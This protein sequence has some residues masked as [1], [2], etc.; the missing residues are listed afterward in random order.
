LTDVKALV[1][2]LTREEKAALTAGED[3]LST[4]AVERLG[5]PKV[6]V[7]DGPNGARGNSLPGMG[8]AASACIPCGSALG[9]TWNPGLVEALGALVGREARER[10][11]R[12]LLAPTVNLHR[13]PL[14]GRNFECYSED[15]LLSG[16]LAAGY[17]RGV[18]S[19]GVFATVKHFVGN[20]A[21]FERASISSVVDERSLRELYL[22]P[23][24]IAV[25]EGG[26]LAIMTAYNRLNGRW[27][28]QRAE[29]LLDILR[30]EWGFKG[31]VMTDWFAVTDTKV[32]LGAGL[33]LEM[34]GPARGLG[35]TVAAAIE[36]GDVDEADLDAAVS[37][38]LGAFDRIGALDG[39]APAIDPKPPTRG[40]VA[41]L[42]RAAAEATVLLS[43]DGVLPL[44]SAAGRVAL[45]GGP[46]LTPTIM[47]GGSA[48]VTPHRVENVVDALALALGPEC[49]VVYE[50]GC[51]PSLSPAVVGGAVL[52]APDGFRAETYDGL[53]LEGPVTE[54]QQLNELR[55]M[56]IG[57]SFE[58]SAGDWSMRVA[59]T[60]VPDETGIFELALA[61][62]GLARL[63][64]NDE[65]VLDGYTN[66]P[67]PGGN[68]FFGQAS[69]DLVADVHFEQGVPVDMVVEYAF[70]D[71]SLAGF[72][73][74]FRTPDG[75]ALLERAVAAAADADVAI[76]CV[77]TSAE[78]ETE[79]RDRTTLA[80]PGRQAE[81]V[82]RVA[83]VNN[84]TVVVVN[85]A[86]PVD[87]EWAEDVAAVLQC[88]F[89]GQE[90]AGG[91]VDVLVGS[92]EP[93]G[94]LPTTIPMRLEHAPS[95]AN[96]P[97]ENGE[98][99][100]GEGLFMG[101]RGYEHNAIAPRFAFGHGLSY[102]S[103]DLGEPTLSTTTH[104]SGGTVRVVVPV[105]NVG[106]RAGSEVVQCYVA[107]VSPR[108]ARPPKELKA[109]GKVALEP[110]ESGVVEF[111]LDD[112]AFA[113]WDPGQD[114]WN[115]VQAFV[116]EMFNFLSPPA[117]RRERGWQ[118][119]PGSYE[120]LI[121]R[122]SDD[123][124]HRCSLSVP[125]TTSRR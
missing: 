59:G 28:T 40:D 105:T 66:R 76:V 45:F 70:S 18:Q 85:A 80:L 111:V 123:L 15:P 117:P 39:P 75:D 64:V 52:R 16:R 100:Y 72:R 71:T 2:A 14:A 38:L 32:S 83:A 121:G 56:K 62:A 74:G 58:A 118:V 49:A 29:F 17:V 82:R 119:D 4:V 104:Q 48:Q 113:Y 57:L 37:R 99:R 22:V 33:D 92:A 46:A 65:V 115:D 25:S 107:P 67:P 11:C 108:L 89:G 1:D 47:G 5:I 79:G 12:G 78:T 86:A 8:G 55:M 125:D 24:E 109:F 19:E 41:L 54:T 43:N 3:M 7:T 23:F 95:H 88:W 6:H 73:V 61:Q 114:D 93:G 98:L 13:S 51:E 81:L 87:M 106:A 36:K 90:T 26:A 60:V 97:G 91:L 120:I 103:F 102:T 10:G 124:A 63:L 84:R 30:D 77:G 42:R 101:Y 116:P 44:A 21:E 69:Q 20:D 35:S 96:F 112:R 34:P 68:D 53:A 50:R 31:L 27:L 94:R 110:G 9:A 122:S